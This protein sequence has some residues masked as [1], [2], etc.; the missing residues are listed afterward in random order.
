MSKTRGVSLKS[1]ASRMLATTRRD[2]RKTRACS[3]HEQDTK[4]LAKAARL[5]EPQGM[6]E[7]ETFA[8]VPN[9]LSPPSV[10]LFLPYMAS[11]FSIFP[12]KNA[13]S[14]RA[15]GGLYRSMLY[16]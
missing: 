15:V 11:D 8:K 10:C 14:H 4:W 7:Y 5:E 2:V 12:D 1:R 16:V 6:S 3:S 9:L 13:L